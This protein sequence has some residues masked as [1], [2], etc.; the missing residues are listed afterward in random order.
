MLQKDDRSA[1]QSVHGALFARAVFCIHPVI[2]A[3]RTDAG[4]RRLFS[5][6][7]NRQPDHEKAP[8]HAALIVAFQEPA[9]RG[10]SF[11]TSA[12]GVRLPGC[13]MCRLFGFERICSDDQ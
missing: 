3:R 1:E 8:L 11:Q 2:A 13:R 12:A 7:G 4:K 6:Q 9:W 10:A 5:S